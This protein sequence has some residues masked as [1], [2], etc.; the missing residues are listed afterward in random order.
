MTYH[1]ESTNWLFSNEFTIS[2]IFM[3]GIVNGYI[4]EIANI[5]EMLT[6]TSF[7]YI[8][9][10]FYATIAWFKSLIR[11]PSFTLGILFLFSVLIFFSCSQNKVVYESVF[12]FG[13]GTLYEIAVSNFLIFFCLCLPPFMLCNCDIDLKKLN[14]YLLRFSKIVLILFVIMMFLQV[15]VYAQKL[16]YMTVAYNAVPSMMIIYY[17]F[18]NK[19]NKFAAVLWTL[20]FASLLIGGCRGALLT[21]IVF[22]ILWE[23]HLFKE[24]TPGKLIGGLLLLFLVFL[25]FINL[26]SIV[27]SL[28]SFLKSFGYSSRL[29]NKFLDQSADG[30]L[31]YFDDRQE[32][33]DL[34][35]SNINFFGHGIYGDRAF[36]EG[37]YVHN[38]VI[39]IMLHYGILFGGIL[40]IYL[41]VFLLKARK[42]AKFLNNDFL[43]LGVTAFFCTAF[44][45]MMFSASYLNDRSFWLFL[46]LCV[47]SSKYNEGRR[48]N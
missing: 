8:I 6:P 23:I 39:E 48:F 25:I 22:V 36:T 32:T 11:K 18:R 33:L 2:I 14:D 20:S 44:V 30:D 7:I 43:F 16:N 27:V 47:I 28:N 35:M 29:L 45:K 38:F 4:A 41:T 37:G 34:A 1:K 10:Y 21:M 17:N 5:W 26:E 13:A 24:I 9:I 40:L 19:P 46:G 15:F 3:L 12:N 42:K 31:F